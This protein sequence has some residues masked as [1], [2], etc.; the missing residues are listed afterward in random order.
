MK[1]QKL[2]DW[3]LSGG[4]RYQNILRAASLN[5]YTIPSS[6][7][8]TKEETAM[9]ALI[10]GGLL[11]KALSGKMFKTDG[12]S[13]YATLDWVNP[14]D[15]TKQ[16]EKVNS[17]IF[18]ADGFN[19]NGTT[20]YLL[21]GLNLA[22]VTQDSVTYC[23]RAFV[24]AATNAR[25]LFGASDGAPGVDDS[26]FFN[27]RN[28]SSQSSY[29]V[30][31]PTSTAVANS[32]NATDRFII[33]RSGGTKYYSKNGAAFSSAAV[34][35]SA[36]TTPKEIALLASNGSSIGSFSTSG[37]SYFWAFNGKLSDAEAAAFD[38]IM[39]NYLA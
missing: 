28:A 27:P 32:T 33:A 11:A 34:A 15:S 39:T 5:G 30:S 14:F 2:L 1:K 3:W 10:A 21:S 4:S 18:S 17:P 37:I 23:A 36:L 22:D 29:S 7:Q 8:Q 9:L 13:D 12:D 20:S 19:S 35:F 38:T 25:A 16:A 26:V 24:N 31:D 6:G